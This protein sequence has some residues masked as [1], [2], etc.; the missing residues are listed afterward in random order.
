MAAPS[1]PVQIEPGHYAR[2][3][4]LSRSS[5]IAWSHR[6]R[7]RTA[8][9]L[10][11][12]L[13][14]NRLL[15]YGCGDGTFLS[16]VGG[17]FAEATGAEIARDVIEDCRRRLSPSGRVQFVFVDDLAAPEFCGR[18][19]VVMCMEVLEH[20]VDATVR[21]VLNDLRR[22]VAP[23][24]LVIISVPIEIG[25]ALAGKQLMRR[26]AG[27]SLKDYR[28]NDRYSSRELLR[29]LFATRRTAI[30]RPVFGT[31]AERHHS[32]KGFNWRALRDEVSGSFKI[33]RTI[34]SPLGS[35]RG[36]LS[37]QAWFVCVPRS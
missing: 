7:F 23:G 13:A 29:M 21:M 31:G 20:C 11:E 32:H 26:I 2:K 18:Y 30:E 27:L 8:R 1:A 34:F 4:I 37:S 3:Q 33:Q 16:E 19:D 24:G 36:Y 17:M 35:L 14:G 25:P 6:S 22:L 10:I 9:R 12:S 5:L 28:Y 15:D